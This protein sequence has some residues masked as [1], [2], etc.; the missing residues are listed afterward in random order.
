ME[1][2]ENVI[3]VSKSKMSNNLCSKIDCMLLVNVLHF[4]SALKGELFLRDHSNF[5]NVLL[6]S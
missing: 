4:V 1:L 6:Q 2:L 3:Y 5:L